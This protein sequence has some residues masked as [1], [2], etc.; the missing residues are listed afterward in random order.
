MSLPLLTT[1][2]GNAISED[3]MQQSIHDDPDGDADSSRLPDINR[4]RGELPAD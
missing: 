4:Q 2:G 1:E 3:I